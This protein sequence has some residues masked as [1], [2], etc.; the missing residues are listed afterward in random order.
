MKTE[1]IF[2]DFFDKHLKGKIDEFEERRLKVIKNRRNAF[3]FVLS[4]IVVHAAATYMEAFPFWTLLVSVAITP[5]ITAWLY[6]RFYTD[7]DM[8]VELKEIAS[9]EA[10]K[11]ILK[12][13]MQADEKKFIEYEDF[14]QSKIFL[15][16]PEHYAG[17]NIV[18]GKLGGYSVVF[19]EI[20]TG[21]HKS[22]DVEKKQNEWASVFNGIFLMGRFRGTF[23]HHIVVVPNELRK[24]FSVLGKKIQQANTFYRDNYLQS[25]TFSEEFLNR[26]AVYGKD[27]VFAAQILTPLIQNLLVQFIDE[28]NIKISLAFHDSRFDFAFDTTEESAEFDLSEP[29][30]DAGAFAGVFRELILALTIINDVSNRLAPIIQRVDW[31]LDDKK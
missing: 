18:K 30:T 27:T 5:L 14:K 16:M 8:W 12:D 25:P 17:R 2:K 23:K 7:D 15:Q 9:K 21:Y 13:T 4:V 31:S 26:F 20:E 11:Y 10:I 19:S 29:L 22:V 24:N 28:S 1:E 3:G 6:K